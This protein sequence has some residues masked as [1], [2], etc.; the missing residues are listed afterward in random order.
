MSV[1]KQQLKQDIEQKSYC[2]YI[3]SINIHAVYK[4]INSISIHDMYVY[5]AMSFCI[6][7][8][9][10]CTKN[11]GCQIRYYLLIHTEKCNFSRNEYSHLPSRYQEN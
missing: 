1:K 2:F 9:P 7:M 5:M 3:Q 10:C 8:S 11:L 4:L 6:H